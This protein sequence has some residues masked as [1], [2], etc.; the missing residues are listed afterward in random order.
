MTD[1]PEC[2]AHVPTDGR[3]CPECGTDIT[4]TSRG[5]T[6]GDHHQGYTERRP[7]EQ[8]PRQGRQRQ[9][10]HGQAP[11][12]QKRRVEP[13]MHPESV[14]PNPEDHKLL[15]GSVLTLSVL[16]LL[17]SINQAVFP[18]TFVDSILEASEDFGM[19]IEQTLAEQ[20]V[21]FSGIVGIVLA[22]TVIGFTI[23]NYRDDVLNKS[24]F[25]ILIG[26]SILGFLMANNFFLLILLA[27][28]IYGLI[29]V[30]D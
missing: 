21:V 12:R 13:S 24:Y 29:S 27:F 23:K 22:I 11:N 15:L 28:G 5:E 19:E 2:G 18:D 3:F 16:G 14:Q 6:N 17:Y 25:W 8:P 1:C 7:T 26:V 4:A 9:P 20:I 10:H 30:M